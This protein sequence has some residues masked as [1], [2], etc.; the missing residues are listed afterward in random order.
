MFTVMGRKTDIL[1]IGFL[2]EIDA[3][4]VVRNVCVCLCNLQQDRSEA[5]MHCT[6]LY[7]AIIAFKHLL[8][9]TRIRAEMCCVFQLAGQLSTSDVL[10][11]LRCR[12]S[13]FFVLSNKN[14]N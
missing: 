7:L 11:P 9:T 12:I 5:C 6:E 1:G 14:K 2:C 8:C 10:V 13:Y 4:N 3:Y